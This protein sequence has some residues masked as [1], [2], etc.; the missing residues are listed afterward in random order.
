MSP[1]FASGTV[2][3]YGGSRWRVQ[4]V[5]GVEAVLLRSDSG[6]E[7][8]VDPLKI[9]WP[10]VAGP[11]RPSPPVLNELRYSEAD[12][13]EAKR[14]HDLLAEL[15]GKSSRTTVD[16]AATAAAL[17]VTPRRVWKLLRRLAIAGNEIAQLL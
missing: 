13:T 10:E 2:V 14:R 9:R 4:R 3:E 17:G 16:V 6:E 15:A 11:S 5:L 8:S 1:Q 12:W 7:V